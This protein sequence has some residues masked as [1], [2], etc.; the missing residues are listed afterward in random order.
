[1]Q[2][3]SKFQWHSSHKQKKKSS[4]NSYGNSK[5]CDSQSNSEQ[6]EH[7]GGIK[8]PNF[9]LYYRIKV[10]KPVSPNRQIDQWNRTEDPEIIPKSDSQLFLDKSTKHT[11]WNEKQP[12]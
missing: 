12:L 11:H 6:K 2:S 9:K 10:P 8:I 1:M 5:G 7:D 3:P 4:Q